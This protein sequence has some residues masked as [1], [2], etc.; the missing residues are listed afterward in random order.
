MG[1]GLNIC[2]S[3]VELLHGNLAHA[4]NPKGGAIFTVR[5]PIAPAEAAPDLAR[6]SA[7]TQGAQP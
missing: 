6:A 3:I 1:M 7:Q 4:P 5:L 2:R